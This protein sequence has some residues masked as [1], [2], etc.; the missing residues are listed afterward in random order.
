[1]INTEVYKMSRKGFARQMI[2]QYGRKWLV[3]YA[4]LVIS[5][6]IVAF[7]VDYRFFLLSLI[8]VFIMIPMQMAFLYYYYGL[9][10]E[11]FMNIVPHKL[12][13]FGEGILVT[14]FFPPY[15]EEASDNL[16]DKNETGEQNE[17]KWEYDGWKESE[18]MIKFG[19]LDR[20]VVGK[21]SVIIPIIG[22]PGG[23]IWLPERA[24]PETAV[25]AD[26][27]SNLKIGEG[28]K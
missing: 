21:D 12:S 4:L 16:S 22:R 15:D 5:S 14:M 11:C 2:K 1:M 24:F 23:F 25:F 19:S 3:A 6:V 17:H 26:F 8:I 7:F 10:R 27:M 18:F 28:Y 13:I 9:N 20:Y